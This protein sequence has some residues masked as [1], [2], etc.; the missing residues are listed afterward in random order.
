MEIVF[1]L[2]IIKSDI[3]VA[4]TSLLKYSSSLSISKQG[5]NKIRE[6]NEYIIL[7]SCQTV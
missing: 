4:K 1:I 6:R 7:Y 3:V 2:I 5:Q